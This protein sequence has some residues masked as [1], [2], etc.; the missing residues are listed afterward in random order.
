[1]ALP[2]AAFFAFAF[3]S[4]LWADDIEAGANLLLFFTLPFAV[5][6]T[7]V[8]RSPLPAWAPRA[9]AA[10][11]ILLASLF[12]VVGLWQI[13]THELF[14]YAPNLAFSNANKDYF[15]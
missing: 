8:A 15:A 2:A 4:L 10:T 7:T 14:F 12:A 1:M 6:L 9:L 13:V 11:A 3:A 5:L